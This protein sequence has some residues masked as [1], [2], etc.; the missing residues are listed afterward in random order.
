MKSTMR[1]LPV[2]ILF[3]SLW[4]TQSL[5][6]SLDSDH[7]YPIHPVP[8]TQ[9]HFDD[10]FWAP[11][12]EQHRTHTLP[13]TMSQCDSTGR[14][15]NFEIAAGE[16]EGAFCTAYPFDDSDLYKIIEGASYSL[17]VHSDSVLE[18]KVDQ[19]ISLIGEAQEA[20]GYLYTTRTIDPDHP[21]AW[22]GARR[23]E[24]TD[25]L[26]HELY[27]AGH[28]FEAAA[29]HYQAT[30]KRSLLD[31]AIRFADLIDHDFGWGKLEKCPGHQVI[32]IGLAKL[33]RITGEKRYL[34]LA[35]FFLDVRGPNQGEYSQAHLK[36]IDQTEAVGHAVRA[37]YMYSGMADIAALTGNQDYIHAIDKIWEDVVSKKLYIT[38]GIGAT[39][40]WEGFGPAYALPNYSAYCETCASIANV[41]WNYRL[42]LLH[43]EAKYMDVL[44]RTLYNA[45]NSGMS[46]EGDRFFYANPLE[47]RKNQQRSPWFSCA[48][49]PSNIARFFPSIPGYQYAVRD[50]QVYVNLFIGGQASLHT[51]AGN[52]E[53]TMQTKYP[54]DGQIELTVLPERT[55]E[56]SMRLRIPGWAR[57]QVVPSDLY[58]F[59][60]KAAESVVIRVNGEVIDYNLEDGYA[61]LTRNWQKGD[62]ISMDIPMPVRLVRA[63]EA[64]ADDT[65]KM[66]LQRGPLVYCFEGADQA[67]ERVNHAL[68][69]N[70][71]RPLVDWN[72]DLLHGVETIRMDGAVA[73]YAPD[74][75]K[76]INP[77]TLTAIPYYAWANR[78]RDYMTIWVAENSE[79]VVPAP[80]P[81]L[82]SRSMVT[83]SAP[84]RNLQAIQDQYLPE[85]SNDHS[86]P[87]LHF[88][89][90][91]G[92]EE[93]L[94]YD[95]PE[96]SRISSSR[97]YWFDDGPE[98]GCRIPASWHLEYRSGDKWEPLKVI[99]DYPIL[100]DAWNEVHFQPVT[101]DAIRLILQA[102]KGV[103]SGIHEWEVSGSE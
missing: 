47:A 67:D 48:C 33:Y 42:F 62:R 78:E 100:K 74:Q 40:A 66:A 70:Q 3:T 25:D 60:T 82:A 18:Q 37:A 21:H 19:W 98:G 17:Q 69:I 9:V 44:E 23:W 12:L 77:L 15:K 56:I 22:A 80:S 92:T 83:C 20:D 91:F 36:V 90:R 75:T 28:L 32:E 51:T 72:E 24:K 13:Y 97:I 38:G 49:C 6:Q 68:F 1:T 86:N 99:G 30:G 101:A 5:A 63:H 16:M 43:G 96:T 76:V 31:I 14:V 61:V 27:N 87:Y 73:T 45:A 71:G 46:L 93:W 11:R 41:F 84:V 35:K 8:F 52:V 59:V 7:D 103:S 95:F 94:Q 57:N 64:V 58:T 39:G 81:T 88:W 85:N 10:A 65:G 102:R 50:N 79:V 26:S 89:P 53:L 34:D 54:W 55:G 2:T 4:C 29:A